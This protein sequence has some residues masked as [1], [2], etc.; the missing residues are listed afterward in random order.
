MTV[1]ERIAAIRGLMADKNIDVYYIPNEDDH[2]SEEYTADHFKCKSF[3]SGFSGESGCVVI[4]QDFCGLWTDGRYFTQ[5]ENELA[6]SD[7]ELMRMGQEGVPAVMDFLIEKTPENGTLGFDGTVVSTAKSFELLRRLKPKQAKLHVGDDLTGMIWTD[8]PAMPG[9]PVYILEEQYT[10]AS[11]AER[12]AMV[13]EK[14]QEKGADVLI[15]TRLEDPCWL[16]NLRG[17][18]IECTPVAYAFAMLD[19]EK[20]YYYIDPAQVDETVCA[21]L[22]ENGVTVRGYDDLAE[23]LAGLHD[24]NIWVNPQSF[25]SRLYSCLAKDNRLISEEGPIALFRAV[26]NET[27]IANTK[28]AHLKDGAAIVRFIKYVKEHVNDGDMTEVS[29]QNELYRLRAAQP[30]YIEPSFP[31]ISAYQANG[32]MMHY[33]ATEEN[34]AKV[35]PRGFLLVDSGGTYKDGTTDITRTIAVG[36]LTDEEKMLYTLVLKGHLNL[37]S[38]KFLKGTT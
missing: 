31:T 36:P 27:E 2:L 30:D 8:R 20:V 19:G 17:N 15:I 12:I 26:K 32:A 9:Q 25:N 4:T 3:V 35:E 16:F 38:A 37:I 1:N 14:M 13:R 18:D 11:A 29:A 24:R 21:Y 22:E 34:H 6:G 33:T 5:A 28:H 7:V 23:D 10:G